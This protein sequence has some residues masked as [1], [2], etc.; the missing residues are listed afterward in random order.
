MAVASFFMPCKK[1]I[2]M[3]FSLALIILLGL[4]SRSLLGKIHLPYIIG[5]LFVGIILGPFGFNILSP[6]LTN[7]SG[8]IREIALIIILMKAGLSLDLKDLKKVGRP[9]ILLCFV[10]ASFEIISYLLF[11]P[12]LMGITIIEAGIIG[13]IMGAVSPAVVVPAMTRLIDEKR[14]TNKAIPQMMLAGSSADD[15]YCIVIFT[16]LSGLAQGGDIHATSF[17]RVPI[18]MIT[19]IALGV[20]SGIMIVQFFRK[21]HMRDT[22]K[23]LVLLSISFLFITL[24]KAIENIVPISGLLAIVSLG[25]IIK[26]KHPILANRITP[27]FSKLWV[28]AEILLF[29]L[30]GALVNINYISTAGI[31]VI[32]MLLIGLI[33]RTVGTFISTTKTGLTRGEQLFCLVSEF[34]KATVQAAMG[35]IPLAMGLA[36]G[37]LALTFAVVGIVITAPLGSF[38]ISITSNRYLSI[39]TDLKQQ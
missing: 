2:F 4:L 29:V 22:M 26:A 39:E 17:L 7:I 25:L 30:V 10:P 1:E 12:H 36:C 19:G 35:G 38:L 13:S 9:A 33:F 15:V 31:N 6:Q 3:L 16:A 34:P 18:S 24:E 21:V 5:M 23:V 11:A 32:F 37:E 14:G 8:D 27:K 20:V 28:G